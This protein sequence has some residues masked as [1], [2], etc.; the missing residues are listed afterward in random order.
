M[1]CLYGGNSQYNMVVQYGYLGW[2]IDHIMISRSCR[3]IWG[4]H[5]QKISQLAIDDVNLAWWFTK[6]AY[7]N[8][9]LQQQWEIRWK[10]SVIERDCNRKWD[11]S[12]LKRWQC[13][14]S[15]SEQLDGEENKEETKG[16]TVNFAV[17]FHVLCDVCHFSSRLPPVAQNH[18]FARA[19][20]WATLFSFFFP[21]RV[22]LYPVQL[23]LWWG[24]VGPPLNRIH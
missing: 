18:P 4:I 20:N 6:I 24:Q 3:G 8:G 13:D 1:I 7:W 17:D 11:L 2:S 15:I 23:A 9:D 19:T 16:E 12:N 21:H 10:R 5:F 14:R 22:I